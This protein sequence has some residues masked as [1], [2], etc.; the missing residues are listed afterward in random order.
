MWMILR[1][2]EAKCFGVADD[3]IV[4]ARADREQDVA[5]LH[6]HVRFVSAVHAEHA[7]KLRIAGGIGTE[8]HQRVGA[9]KA[10]QI[11]ERA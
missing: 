10:E 5:V 6:R 1:S 8:A 7:E 11:D 3:A 9:R 2:T 4:E